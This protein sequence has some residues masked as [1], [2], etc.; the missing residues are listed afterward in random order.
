MFYCWRPPVGLLS[1]REHRGPVFCF[2]DTLCCVPSTKRISGPY[3]VDAWLLCPCLRQ[4][5]LLSR[6]ISGSRRVL[7]YPSRDVGVS[8][9]E[10]AYPHLDVAEL[11]TPCR[12]Y[13]LLGDIPVRVYGS[14]NGP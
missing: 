12:R 2:D 1:S 13:C 9:A 11:R 5:Y 10:S 14:P 8:S 7:L 4:P 6:A 3:A